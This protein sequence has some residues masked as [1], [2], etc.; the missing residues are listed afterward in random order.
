[1]RHGGAVRADRRPGVRP[2]CVRGT[3]EAAQR[4]VLEAD[5]INAKFVIDVLHLMRSGG[6]PET[7]RS[8]VPDA[9]RSASWQTFSEPRPKD[10]A[11][12]REEARTDRRYPGQGEAP[13][14]AILDALPHSVD[15]PT[16]R[17][18]HKI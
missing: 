15:G 5:R 16:G 13:L 12:L 1:M 2:Y 11:A 9:S 8:L 4:L 17:Y 10:T 6:G 14:T 18:V 3:L 7:L